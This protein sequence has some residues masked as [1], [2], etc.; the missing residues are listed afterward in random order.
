MKLVACLSA[1]EWVGLGKKTSVKSVKTVLKWFRAAEIPE[2]TIVAL[3]EKLAR[4]VKSL[5]AGRAVALT[6][7]AAEVPKRG[8]MAE[9]VERSMKSLMAVRVAVL[10]TRAAQVMALDGCMK[11]ATEEDPLSISIPEQLKLTVLL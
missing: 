6:T 3:A 2:V 10:A 4:S 9:K 11:E 8:V 5:M 7:R 1:A